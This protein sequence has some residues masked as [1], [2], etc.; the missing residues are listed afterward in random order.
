MPDVD[1]A[2]LLEQ[3]AALDAQLEAAEAG[4]LAEL[5]AA[6]EAY[7]ADP[8][9]ENKVRKAAAVGA[10]QQLRAHLRVGRTSNQVGGDAFV[11]TPSEG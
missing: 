7:R 9:P 8:S 3:R 11:S 6:K 5:V 2:A 1:V 4:V 10:V